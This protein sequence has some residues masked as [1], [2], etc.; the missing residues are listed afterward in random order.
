M[1]N[2][3]K[4]L[5]RNLRD[6]IVGFEGEESFIVPKYDV[7]GDINNDKYVMV[8][9]KSEV[10]DGAIPKFE[11]APTT[12]PKPTA[13]TPAPRPTASTPAPVSAPRP[14]STPT[15]STTSTTTPRPVAETTTPRSV[16][17]TT[18]ASTPRPVS[19][20]TPTAS[21]TPLPTFPNFNNL[22]REE[23]HAQIMSLGRMRFDTTKYTP[24]QI[25]VLNNTHSQAMALY[26]SKFGTTRPK[27][28]TIPMPVFPNLQSMSCDGLTSE[29]TRIENLLKVSK[30][31]SVEIANAYNNHLANAKNLRTQKCTKTATPQVPLPTFPNFATLNCGQ[32]NAEI[33]KIQNTMATSRFG[34]ADVTNAYNKALETARGFLQRKCYPRTPPT[35]TPTPTPTPSPTPAPKPPT[36]VGGG[37]GGIGGGK[38]TQEGEPTEELP[39]EEA[40]VKKPNYSWLWILL[41]VGG[42]YMLTRKGKKINIQ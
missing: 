16:T 4:P 38:P 34:S 33:T 11:S 6:V 24:A 17:P 13:S 32:L 30:L 1:I 41:L 20:T 15:L 19:T 10:G 5:R 26:N 18:T 23:L 36:P 9:G 35:P 37:G 7:N 39:Q 42:V 29:I 12:A 25:Q 31:P 21:T 22:S 27:G 3:I 40:Q 28:T 14:T 8:T 2:E